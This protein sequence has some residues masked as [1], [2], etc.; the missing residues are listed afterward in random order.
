MPVF[1]KVAAHS[2]RQ[3]ACPYC[4]TTMNGRDKHPRAPTRDHVQAKSVGGSRAPENFVM[5]CRL[6]NG[7]KG[8]MTLEEF[9]A[10]L[11]QRG[12]KRARHVA[13]FIDLWN[14]K[15]S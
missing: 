4:G 11:D 8:R 5:V 9:H 6:C 7:H 15:R 14:A 10:W 1:G 12:D 13:A 2:A 3:T